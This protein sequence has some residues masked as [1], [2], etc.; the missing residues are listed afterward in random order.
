MHC[1]IQKRGLGQYKVQI[2]SQALKLLATATGGDLR[3]A[4][5]GLELAVKST[6]PGHNQQIHISLATVEDS[7]QKKSILADKNGDHHY[8]IISAF[9][10]SI[11]GSD[12]DAAI[13]YLAYLLAASDLNSIIRRLIVCA[14]EDVGLANPAACKRA[15]LACQA[16]QQIGL[17]EAR[18]PLADTVIDLCLSPKSN[19][20]LKAID[21]ALQ[22]IQTGKTGTIPNTLK[23][24]H[25]Q[26]A[27]ALNHGIDYLYPH[28]YPNDWV[29]QQYLPK[30][31]EHQQ[32]YR[33]K[34]NG[35]YEQRLQKTYYNL[36]KLQGLTHD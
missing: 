14:Y 3:S 10:K 36:K 25:Y 34:S 21:Q 30:G 8:D 5:N 28:D 27:R 24:A 32:Y 33:P 20:C 7:I 13:Y 1:K 9:Q 4:L 6:P 35:K 22:D 31:L 2:S 16:A 23:D 26:G 18:I 12:T 29:R 11:R 15:V 17:P 19:S